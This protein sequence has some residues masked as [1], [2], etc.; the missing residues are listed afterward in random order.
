MPMFFP[1]E[2]SDRERVDVDDAGVDGEGVIEAGSD[3]GAPER[4][5]PKASFLSQREHKEPPP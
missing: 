2:D 4:S 5:P 1:I 3:D